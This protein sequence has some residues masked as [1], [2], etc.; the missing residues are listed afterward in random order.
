MLSNERL[1]FVRDAVS[2]GLFVKKKLYV[3]RGNICRSERDGNHT[4]VDGI[5]L[6]TRVHD[7][8]NGISNT[9]NMVMS[10]HSYKTKYGVFVPFPSISPLYEH[11]AEIEN[12]LTQTRQY[13][14]DNRDEVIAEITIS[15]EKDIR[16]MWTSLGRPG[17]PPQPFID[18]EIRQYI[19]KIPNDDELA[20]MF[21]LKLFPFS[22]ILPKSSPY[23]SVGSVDEH[24]MQVYRA[25]YDAVLERRMWLATFC[26]K[27]VAEGLNSPTSARGVFNRL[28]GFKRNMFY[29]EE[30]LSSLISTAMDLLIVNYKQNEPESLKLL[31]QIKS[32]VINDKFFLQGVRV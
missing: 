21:I 29:D 11:I 28:R 24:N 12:R 22:P 13:L 20:N 19:K 32:I 18:T 10:D 14:I 1:D 3:W 30:E 23:S 8:V 7:N 9:V 17:N 2:K 15:L 25:I 26:G 27:A 6:K 4:V 31:D 5:R 16:K